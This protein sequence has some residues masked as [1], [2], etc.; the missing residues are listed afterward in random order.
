M[1]RCCVTGCDWIAL[2]I[3][4]HHL[5]EAHGM[6]R[7]QAIQKHGPHTLL[8]M[9][10]RKAHDNLQQ[11]V[12]YDKPHLVQVGRLDPTA[13]GRGRDRRVQR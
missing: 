11:Y 9:D 3:T 1:Y 13:A 4:S 10:G 12:P 7:Q 2:Y 6:T 5:K 8:K